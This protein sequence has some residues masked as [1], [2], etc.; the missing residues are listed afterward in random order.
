VVEDVAR[1]D[2]ALLQAQS[3]DASTVE[4]TARPFLGSYRVAADEAMS[5]AYVVGM[6]GPRSSPR[7]RTA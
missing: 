4:S 1:Q 7:R 6:V 3:V 5:E 2:V